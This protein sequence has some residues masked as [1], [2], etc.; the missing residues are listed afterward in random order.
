MEKIKLTPS[1]SLLKQTIPKRILHPL[2]V[3]GYL[4]RSKKGMALVF[5][6][7][8]LPTFSIKIFLI[9]YPIKCP[10]FNN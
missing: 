8:F 5:I 10:T 6:A 9:K 4:P 2:A 7:Y 1:W 3:F